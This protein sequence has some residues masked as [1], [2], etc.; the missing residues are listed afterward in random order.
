MHLTVLENSLW[1]GKDIFP[2]KRQ[3][4]W[5][6]SWGTAKR[7]IFVECERYFSPTTGNGYIKTML[8]AVIGTVT[9]VS[10]QPVCYMHSYMHSWFTCLTSKESGFRFSLPTEPA[11]LQLDCSRHY[12]SSSVKDIIDLCL[13]SFSLKEKQLHVFPIRKHHS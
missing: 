7:E 9:S 8:P 2:G 11:R 10:T 3:I 13:V 12:V 5:S 4:P 1:R 6:C